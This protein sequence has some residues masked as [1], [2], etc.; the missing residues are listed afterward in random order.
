MT[1]WKTSAV[2]IIL[3]ILGMVGIKFSC[4]DAVAGGAII[5]AGLGF[6]AAKD[7]NVHGGTVPQGTPSKVEEKSQS[8]GQ[9]KP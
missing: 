8:M 6:L 5:T 9:V 3:I 2:G 4:V 1:N 7:F